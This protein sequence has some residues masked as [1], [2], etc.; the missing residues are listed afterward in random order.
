MANGD[1]HPCVYCR[2]RKF[3]A[4]SHI[5]L[6]ASSGLS[7]IPSTNPF[8]KPSPY[9]SHATK[10]HRVHTQGCGNLTVHASYPLDG[11]SPCLIDVGPFPSPRRLSRIARESQGR[12]RS[13]FFGLGK[14][15]AHACDAVL[16][17]RR[18]VGCI[19]CLL[20]DTFG[21]CSLFAHFYHTRPVGSSTTFAAIGTSI[22]P[23]AVTDLTSQWYH[24]SSYWQTS[25]LGAMRGRLDPVV[26]MTSLDAGLEILE[27]ISQGRNRMGM[28]TPVLA[29]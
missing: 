28:L 18:A 14:G 17:Y 4:V 12:W 13:T 29:G 24:I 6:F 21:H 20:S 3:H 19:D 27:P 5:H 10:H 16:S 7:C 23:G 2:K 25:Y 1:Y 22:Q 11:Y 15:F 9:K 26:N 8:S